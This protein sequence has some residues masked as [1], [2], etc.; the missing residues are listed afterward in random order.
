[1]PR[2]R[3]VCAIIA[4]IASFVVTPLV[5][6]D[7]PGDKQPGAGD[8]PLRAL[9][10]VTVFVRDYDEALSWYVDK[11][12]LVK[13]E[14]RRFGA[15]E[16]WLTVAPSADAATRIVLAVPS[17]GLAGSIGHQHNWVFRTGDCRTTHALLSSRGVHFLQEP[18][19]AP[20][21]CQAIIE[22]LYG[23]HIVLLGSA[24]A[25]ES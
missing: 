2:R 21:G 17:P 15:N 23:N 11:L 9:E 4:A 16:R 14:D 3:S 20:W 24:T 6:A 1:M 22:D 12:G 8:A 25:G 7:S 5:L 18:R 10:H 13:T 19:E